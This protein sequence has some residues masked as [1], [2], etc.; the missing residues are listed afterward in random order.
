MSLLPVMVIF[1]L[2]FP[3]IFLE[4]LISLALF[5]CAPHPTTNRYLRVCLAPGSFNTALYCCLFY[6]TSRLFPEVTVST[7][8]LKIIR[9]GI[10]VLV[11]VLAVI[12][13]FN[14]WAFYTESPW[15]RDA[16]FTADVVAIAPDVS[17]LL[18]EVPVKTT[19]W[20]RKA[21][22]CLSLISP[23]IS[24]RWLKPR[25]MWPITRPWLRRS[26]GSPVGGT[27]W[28]FKHCHKKRLTR[29]AMCYKPS[30]TS[31]QKPLPCEI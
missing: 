3:P 31:W 4:L 6:L 9:V 7:F 22:F 30:S 24:R 5:C 2:S 10:T 29:Q 28:V 13:I 16:K 25:P 26:N 1:G 14:V 19:N 18:T 11:V 27:A 15:T 12:A 17:G 21:R 8:S 23:V 20:C